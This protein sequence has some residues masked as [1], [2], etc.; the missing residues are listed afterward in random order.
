VAEG[1]ADWE[2]VCAFALTLLETAM[3][4]WYGRPTPKVAG[5]AFLGEGREARSFCLMLPIA[6]KDVLMESAPDVFWETDHYRGWPAVL[7]RFGA[8]ER[9]WLETLVKR[10]WW[11]KVPARL[12]KAHGPRP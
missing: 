1:F 7:V 11:D 9:E 8:S 12:R 5:K 10:A 4:A 2:E 6:D 3:E